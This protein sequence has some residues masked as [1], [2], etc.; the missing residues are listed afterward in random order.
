MARQIHDG[1]MTRTPTPKPPAENYV[2]AKHFSDIVRKSSLT[3]QQKST[4]IGQAVH[5]DMAGAQKGY[6]RLM[7]GEDN[8]M[9]NRK[10]PGRCV[11]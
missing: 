1:R 7:R 3:P 6:D 5:G 10:R 4:L 11:P 8:D 9:M 2:R